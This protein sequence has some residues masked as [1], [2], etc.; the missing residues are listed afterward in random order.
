MQRPLRPRRGSLSGC[1]NIM[2]KKSVVLIGGGLQEVE[3]VRIAQKAGFRVIV[4]DRSPE[5][6]CF[7]LADHGQ[8]IDGSD[9]AALTS[10]VLERKEEENIVAVFTLTELVRGVAAVVQAAE[11][12]G[13]SPKSAEICQDKALFKKV[14]VKNRVPTPG[15]FILNSFCEAEKALDELGGTAFVKPVV[16]FGGSGA[17]RID[18]PGELCF[19]FKNHK[20]RALLMEEFACGS[21]HDVN[22][23]FDAEGNFHL[24]GCFD[25]FFHVDY[26]VE[27]GARY[28]S[29]LDASSQAR[30]AEVTEQAARAAGITSGPVKADLVMTGQGCKILEMAP[31]LHGPKGTLFLTRMA[32]G[33][34]HLETMLRVFSE[35][36]IGDKDICV[37]PDKAAAYRAVLATPGRIREIRGV[38]EA[39]ALDGVEKVMLLKKAGDDIPE[40]R[41]SRGVPCYVFA[42][43]ASNDQAEARIEEAISIIDF[44]L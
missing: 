22:G 16:G 1:F 10:F 18:S 25:R 42:T 37:I 19:Y 41:D 30:L 4:T 20:G 27:V 36:L 26:P 21:M 38:E 29:L 24:L 44:V 3:A 13:A 40:H 9:G 28:P 43:G 33:V 35:G 7:E 34:S 6:P 31:R 39:E 17:M 12:P 8:V 5:A 23:L 15:G 11:L 2:K 32:T 14:M